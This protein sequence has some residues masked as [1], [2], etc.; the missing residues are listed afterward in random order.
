MLT[1]ATGFIGQALLEELVA[2]NYNVVASVR[3]DSIHLPGT[4]KKVTVGQLSDTTDWSIALR[5]INVVIHVAARAHILEAEA[6]SEFRK[7]NTKGTLNLARQAVARGVKRFIFVS[8]IGVNGNNNT[9]PFTEQEAPAPKAPYGISKWRAEVGLMAIAKKTGMEFVIIRPPLVYGSGASGNF[10]SLIKWCNKRAPLPLGAVKNKR[11]FIAL[12]NLT[13]FITYCIVHPKAANEIFLISDGEDVSTTELLRKVAHAFGKKPV[14]I[15]I[16][17]SL[18]KFVAKLLGKS[19]VAN[20]LFASLQV[21]SSKARNLLDWKPVI[22]M[23]EQLKK[24]VDAY[25]K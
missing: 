14:L 10:A 11:S 16:P 25:K 23:D 3:N 19:D 5:K 21:D 8:S 4:V 22:T 12:D 20:R 13:N 17:V 9:K 6:Q 1:G 15:P 18:M 2:Q 24:T 7:V